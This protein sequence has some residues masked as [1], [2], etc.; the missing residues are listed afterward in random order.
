MCTTSVDSVV[1]FGASSFLQHNEKIEDYIRHVTNVVI[2]AKLFNSNLATYQVSTAKVT[3]V[4]VD[5]GQKMEE[6]LNDMRSLCNGL[7]T[8]P[9]QATPLEL[10]PNISMDTK[11]ISSLNASKPEAAQ[12]FQMPTK[13]DRLEASKQAKDT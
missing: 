7:K 6:I 3:I 4:L 8:T 9:L 11:E 13:V 12:T 5:F 10:V 1:E 2:K